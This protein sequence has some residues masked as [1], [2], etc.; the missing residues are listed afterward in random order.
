M[1][2]DLREEGLRIYYGV[3]VFYCWSFG[4]EHW[5]LRDWLVGIGPRNRRLVT[6]VYFNSRRA[7]VEDTNVKGGSEL[8]VG[9]E[10]GVIEEEMDILRRF[11]YGDENTGGE[12]R[13]VLLWS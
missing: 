8:P 10:V 2:R 13:R 5:K 4:A 11:G 12:T 6:R 7:L 1:C 3:N 9:E